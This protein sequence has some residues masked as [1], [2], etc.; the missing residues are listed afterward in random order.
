MN[1]NI[2]TNIHIYE[3]T[4]PI[5]HSFETVPQ[6]LLQ[7]FIYFDIIN[8]RDWN[9]ITDRD[10]IL[11]IGSATFNS[12]VQVFRLM[13][14]SEAVKETFIQYSLNCITARYVFARTLFFE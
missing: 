3:H 9:E 10:L 7:A 13:K 5:L 11:S 14:E 12:L 1:V 8:G 6:V 2:N 4:K